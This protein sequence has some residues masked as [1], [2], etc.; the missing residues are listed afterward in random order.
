MSRPQTALVTGAAGFIGA[1]VARR[2]VSSGVRVIALDDLSA[3]DPARLEGLPGER[4]EVVR[5]DASDRGRLLGL[6]DEAPEVVI[7]LAGRVGV[8]TV[9]SDPEVCERENIELGEAVAGAIAQGAA[10]GRPR[11]RVLAA[12]TSEVY[13]ESAAPLAEGSDLRGLAASGRWR[14]AASKLACEDAFDRV[15]GGDGPRPVHLRFFNVVGPGQD[16]SSGMVLPRFVEA[17]RTSAPLTIHG[18]GTSVRTFAHVES[19]AGDIAALAFPDRFG[20]RAQAG[21]RAAFTGALNLGGV[22]RSTVLELAQ[23]VARA[24]ARRRL[25]PSPLVHVDPRQTISPDFAEVLHRV[26]DLSR[27]RSLGLGRE[28][29]LLPDIVEDTFARHT[30]PSASEVRALLC[31]SPAS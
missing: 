25:V 19:V 6:L 11:P 16:G 10:R 28:P 31:A 8:R 20:P 27:L 7:H 14:Y 9:L 13:A 18:R 17:A 30:S 4:L 3:G 29:W 15:L 5:G 21:A 1:A 22:A 26:P 24:A 23:E 2:L 12:S